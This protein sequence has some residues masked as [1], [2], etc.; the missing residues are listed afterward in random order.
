MIVANSVSD[1]EIVV[2]NE[3]MQG[4]LSK[5]SEAQNPADSQAWWAF[6]N[7]KHIDRWNMVGKEV[8]GFSFWPPW[9]SAK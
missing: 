2:Q 9:V 1:L 8:K 3:K 6:L 5:S 7:R 4:A